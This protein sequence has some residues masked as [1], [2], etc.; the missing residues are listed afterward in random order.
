MC[1]TSEQSFLWLQSGLVFAVLTPGPEE[2]KPLGLPLLT[3]LPPLGTK[4][5]QTVK[6]G[7]PSLR[8]LKGRGNSTLWSGQPSLKEQSVEETSSKNSKITI[9]LRMEI[10]ALSQAHNDISQQRPS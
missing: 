2:Q 1:Q 8:R 5:D 4:G 7:E 6:K 10:E 3:A 9:K